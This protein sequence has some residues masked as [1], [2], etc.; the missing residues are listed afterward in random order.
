MAYNFPNPAHNDITIKFGLPEDGH[1]QL[2]LFNAQGSLVETLSSSFYEAG[3]HEV[4]L[5]VSGLANGVY[6]YQLRSNDV[7]LSN[8]VI[9]VR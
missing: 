2:Q 7:S 9:V 1:L 5:S 6:F 4:T 3:Y 8:Q